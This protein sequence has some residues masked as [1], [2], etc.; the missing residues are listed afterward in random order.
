MVIQGIEV[1]PVE[2][3][4]KTW[5]KKFIVNVFKEADNIITPP[6]KKVDTK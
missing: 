6:V 2:W 1:R 3:F 5:I 4:D